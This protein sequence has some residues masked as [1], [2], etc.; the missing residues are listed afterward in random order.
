[1]EMETIETKTTETKVTETP[2]KKK[3]ETTV[4]TKAEIPANS[5][6]VNT[7]IGLGATQLR[8]Q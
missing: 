3:I 6:V 8:T 5:A 4:E 7:G 1:M 2:A